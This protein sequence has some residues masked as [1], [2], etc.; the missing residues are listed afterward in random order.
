MSRYVAPAL[1]A[2]ALLLG[3][4]LPARSL[5]DPSTRP[6]VVTITGMVK[7]APPGAEEAATVLADKVNYRIVKDVKGQVV[8]RAAAGKKAEIR[9]SVEDRNGVKWV[10][11]NWCAL[12]E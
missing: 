12:V 6:A 1:V 9:G 2:A 11:V 5:G 8:A 3:A 7:A 10:T 4:L